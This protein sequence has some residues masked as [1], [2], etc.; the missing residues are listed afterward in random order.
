MSRRL[1]QV[2]AGVSLGL[3]LA[4]LIGRPEAGGAIR[5][6][7]EFLLPGPLPAPDAELVSHTGETVRLSELRAGRTLVLFFGYTHCPD[8]CPLTMAALGRA[9]QLLGQDGERVVGALVT[10]DPAR[11]SVAQLAAYLSRF[12]PG[13]IGLTGAP[14]TLAEVAR[15]YLVTATPGAP[16]AAAE[17]GAHAA[18]TPDPSAHSGHAPPAAGGS[19]DPAAYTVEHTGRAYVVHD[20]AIRMTFPPMTDA[21]QMAAGLKLLLDP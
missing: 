16:A 15:G 7:E 1:L 12:P 5:P 6:G 14:E 20:G 17:H 18:G 10:V 21:A 19:P 11:D 9:R 3:L 8:V 13:L 2:A 4:L